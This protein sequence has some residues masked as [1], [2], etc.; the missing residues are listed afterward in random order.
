ME[1]GPPAWRDIHQIL[2]SSSQR[3]KMASPW[4]LFICRL[5]LTIIIMKNTV[6]SLILSLPMKA[7]DEALG[8]G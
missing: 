2:L 6:T 7:R 3:G 8:V 1:F 4:A 5:E